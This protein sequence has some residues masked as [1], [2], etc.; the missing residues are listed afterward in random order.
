[1]SH[2]F[3]YH[4]WVKVA[5]LPAGV[6]PKMN[7]RNSSCAGDKTCKWGGDRGVH[8]GPTE[9]TDVLQ[10]LKKKSFVVT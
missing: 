4:Q 8:H 7:L 10:K 9:R 2:G 3:D 1:M 5:W 6:A